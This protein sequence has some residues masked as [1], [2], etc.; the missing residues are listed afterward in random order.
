M[1]TILKIVGGILLAI[2]AVWLLRNSRAVTGSARYQTVRTEGAVELRDYPALT[3]ATAPMD[4]NRGN[5][6]F[7]RLF[8]FISG[9]N[10]Q[11]Q[12]I[13]RANKP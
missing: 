2:P 13:P 12:K 4:D 9:K 10:T 1:K 3:L 7:G 8:G 5:G 6:S 11:A